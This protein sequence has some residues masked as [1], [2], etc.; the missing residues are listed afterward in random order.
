MFCPNCKHQDTKVLE[1]RVVEDGGAIRRRRKCLKCEHRF[2]TYERVEVSNL[3]IIK[4][5]GSREAFNRTKLASGIYR[6]L[7]KRP[8]SAD[9][10]EQIVGRIE[11]II[12]AQGQAEISSAELGET[13]MSQLK[14][15]DDVAYVRFASVYRS[16]AD[17]ASFEEVLKV[18]K[19][20]KDT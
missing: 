11:N 6:A 8:I 17:L 5:D 4:K 10:R 12:H 19:D 3:L 1:S 16:F 18:L 13:V 7:E 2:T 20:N 9:A 14:Q 15:V